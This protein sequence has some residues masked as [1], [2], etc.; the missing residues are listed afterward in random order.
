MRRSTFGTATKVSQVTNR[1][2]TMNEAKHGRAFHFVL[3]PTNYFYLCISSDAFL[4]SI[5]S[6]TGLP[7][8]LYSR[9]P[10]TILHFTAYGNF[11]LVPNLHF[12]SC[13]SCHAR[14]RQNQCQLL[15]TEPTMIGYQLGSNFTLHLHPWDSK[16]TT[17]SVHFLWVCLIILIMVVG[18]LLRLK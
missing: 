9:T 18:A 11:S 14:T 6:P 12:S 5:S 4:T 2:Q 17:R 16:C 13:R 8:S 7:N 10:T 3:L 1:L 15:I